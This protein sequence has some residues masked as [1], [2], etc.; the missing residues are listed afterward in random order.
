MDETTG[1]LEFECSIILHTLLPSI[2]TRLNQTD[3]HHVGFNN[4]HTFFVLFTTIPRELWTE[5]RKGVANPS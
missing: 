3:A 5:S 1:Y 4:K 2:S